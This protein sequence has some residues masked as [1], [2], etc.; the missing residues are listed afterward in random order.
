MRSR[1]SIAL[2]LITLS[3]IP[4]LAIAEATNTAAAEFV[5]RYRLGNNLKSMALATAQRTQT[6]ASLVSNLGMLKANELLSQELDNH[7]QE[8]EKQ[9]SDNLAKAYAQ[10]FTPEEL[11]SLA[12]EG[13]NS[14]F[15]R[16]LGEKQGDVGAS[17]Q[18]MSTPVLMAYVSASLQSALTRSSSR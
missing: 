17:M 16:K 15:G 6:F 18:R 1:L 7:A 4:V 5:E 14:R 13:R 11:A 12:S 10:H 3:G 8:Y 9:W 2:L